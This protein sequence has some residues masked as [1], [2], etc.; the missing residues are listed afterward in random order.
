MSSSPNEAEAAVKAVLD[1]YAEAVYQGDAETLKDIFHPVACMNGYLGDK[2]LLGGPEPFL[3]DIG[4]HPPMAGDGTPFKA[5]FSAI[6]VSGRTATAT[7]HET[8]FFG[9]GKFVNYFH[10]LYDGGEWKIVS[11]T[12]E[13]L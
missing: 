13:S 8:G 5:E 6:H 3:A 10:L 2:L 7:L 9:S 12:F 11:K 1:R 4:G